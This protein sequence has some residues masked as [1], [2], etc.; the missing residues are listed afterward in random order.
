MSK[1]IRDQLRAIES[2][3][4][5]WDP[6]GVVTNTDGRFDEYDAYA[7]AILKQ[8]R[9][10]T[11]ADAMLLHLHGLVV[12]DMG[13]LSDVGRERDFALKLVVWWANERDIDDLS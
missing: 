9:N 10:G 6:I 1:A 2:M 5:T 4:R 8:L 11:N 12:R 7:P 13:V 3:L